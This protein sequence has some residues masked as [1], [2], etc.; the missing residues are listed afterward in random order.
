MHSNIEINKDDPAY[1]PK[2]DPAM[3]SSRKKTN[4]GL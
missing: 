2:Y 3:N 4:R 1:E